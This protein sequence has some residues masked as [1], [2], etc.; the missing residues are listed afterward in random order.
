MVSTAP[1]AELPDWFWNGCPNVKRHL[2]VHLRNALHINLSNLLVD[3]ELSGVH[4][5]TFHPLD[6][7]QLT[8]VILK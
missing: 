5:D 6:E 2:P 4:T 7:N 8:D 3:D 1:A